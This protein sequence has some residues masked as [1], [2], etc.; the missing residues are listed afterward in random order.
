MLPFDDIELPDVDKVQPGE[1]AI[2]RLLEEPFNDY[3]N[4]EQE[5]MLETQHDPQLETRH[6]LG[7]S[8]EPLTMDENYD[9]AQDQIESMSDSGLYRD[10]IRKS[11][12]YKW[13]VASLQREVIL[14]RG[15]PDI[16]ENIKKMIFSAMPSPHKIS[17]KEPSQ[18]YKAIFELEWS[19]LDFVREQRYTGNPE[20]ALERAITLTGCSNDAQALPTEAYLNQTWPT[21]GKN[22]MKLITDVVR[23]P[24]GHHVNCEYMAFR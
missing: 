10:F 21:T 17:R 11:P 2:A 13:L 23:K 15:T 24:R 19:P 16:M 6:D 14:A 5:S 8:L 9:T 3:S 1:F 20:E 22:V 4:G 18:A 12:A 7:P